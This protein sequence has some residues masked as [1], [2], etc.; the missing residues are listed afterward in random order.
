VKG[1]KVVNPAT[2]AWSEDAL[3]TV[4]IRQLPGDDNALGDIKF[5]FPNPHDV[6]L[7]DTPSRGLFARPA[8]ALSHGCVRVDNPFAFADALLSEEPELTA[9]KLKGMVG[10]KQAWL[11]L[12]VK[13]PVHLAYFTREVGAG[14]EVVRH[15]DVYGLDARTLAALA[16]R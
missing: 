9:A 6:Y 7:H 15:G 11:N 2:V 10:G 5:L 8:R 4:Q 3:K 14:G 1:G 13:I 12:A 16:R